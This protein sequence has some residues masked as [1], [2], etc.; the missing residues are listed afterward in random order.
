MVDQLNDAE[1]RREDGPDILPK[2]RVV[3]G[4]REALKASDHEGL[5]QFKPLTAESRLGM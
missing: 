1:T 2:L 5:T 4:E 3:F